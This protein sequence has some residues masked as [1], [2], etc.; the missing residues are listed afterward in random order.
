MNIETM[1]WVHADLKK[2]KQGGKKENDT[3]HI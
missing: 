2:I 1:K 3:R